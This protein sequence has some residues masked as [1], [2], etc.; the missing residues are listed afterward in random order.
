MHGGNLELLNMITVRKVQYCLVVIMYI[1]LPIIRLISVFCL[2]E[3]CKVL[4]EVAID[5]P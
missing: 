2:I 4:R 5:R 1:Q 3:V